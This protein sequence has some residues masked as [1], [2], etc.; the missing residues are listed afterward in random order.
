MYTSCF[1][2][3][4]YWLRTGGVVYFI[5]CSDSQHSATACCSPRPGSPDAVCSYL[6]RT[7]SADRIPQF[8]GRDNSHT[9][10]LL[11]T[12][13]LYCSCPHHPSISRTFT[14]DPRHFPTG[15][16]ASPLNARF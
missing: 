5:F 4:L 13:L 6:D 10:Y 16:R 1:S 14:V 8:Q 3:Y 7:T 15:L 12:L 9:F 11:L 2:C